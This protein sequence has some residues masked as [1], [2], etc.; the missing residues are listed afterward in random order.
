M[1]FFSSSRRSPFGAHTPFAAAH[2]GGKRQRMERYCPAYHPLS[3]TK[4]DGPWLGSSS[5]SI[6]SR[7]STPIGERGLMIDLLSETVL[8][9]L[10][11]IALVVGICF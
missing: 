7:E 3:M 6:L 2:A 11:D 5:S 9:V 1:R 8:V 4:L 10:F